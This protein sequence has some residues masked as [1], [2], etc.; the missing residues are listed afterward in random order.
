ML[1][2]ADSATFFQFVTVLSRVRFLIGKNV[3]HCAH[4]VRCRW[5]SFNEFGYLFRSSTNGIMLM[6]A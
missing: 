2:F 4:E 5:L 3:A 1:L 6:H